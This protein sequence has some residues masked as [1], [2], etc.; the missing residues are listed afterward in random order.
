M[1]KHTLSSTLLWAWQFYVGLPAE[2]SSWSRQIGRL[3]SESSLFFAQWGVCL[4]GD[5][6]EVELAKPVVVREKG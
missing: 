1:H 2:G 3:P 6:R 5:I 4:F